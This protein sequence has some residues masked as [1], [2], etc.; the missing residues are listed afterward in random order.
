[1]SYQ[2]WACISFT[3]TA[4]TTNQ[5]TRMHASINNPLGPIFSRVSEDNV[6]QLS[7]TNTSATIRIHAAKNN[8]STS[9]AATITHSGNARAY[10]VAG[11]AV[12][13][14]PGVTLSPNSSGI[15]QASISN[16]N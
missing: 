10:Y 5:R 16:C 4:I 11:N 1:M 13:F 2:P 12:T 9:A 14:S 8:Y 6:L 15:I 7:L 3:G